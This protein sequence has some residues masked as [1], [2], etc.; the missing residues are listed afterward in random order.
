MSDD[1]SIV[2]AYIEATQHARETQLPEHFA[3][4][5]E[6]LADDIEIRVAS[7]WTDEP[8]REMY[9]T[10]DQVIERLKAPINKGSVLTTV[11]ANVTQAGKDVLVEQHS[12]IVRDG[13]SHV[14]M[15]CHIF[16]VEGGKVA[17]IRT[18]R[19]E[20]GIPPG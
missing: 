8:W 1:V 6:F 20:D 18:Y 2:R 10:A 9:T 5:R 17:A 13:R 14:S 16:T 4:I 11:N 3:A 12:T 19:N 15:V 7:P